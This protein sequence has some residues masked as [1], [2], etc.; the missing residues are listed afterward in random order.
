MPD[1]RA[2]GRSDSY[3]ITMGAQERY[4]A[5]A[6]AYWASVRSS[7]KVPIFLMGVSMGAATVLLASGLDLPDSVHGIIA[8]C[9]YP[10]HLPHLSAQVP[11]ARAGGA[12][13]CRRQSWCQDLRPL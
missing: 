13:L 9:G 3:T 12:W 2:H 1:Q 7:G 5:R 6:W 11:A 4:D 10:G 8:D